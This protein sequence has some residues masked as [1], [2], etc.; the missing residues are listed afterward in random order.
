MEIQ[1]KINELM[2]DKDF[3]EAFQNVSAPEEVVELFGRNGV[4][5]PLAVAQE[6]FQ[7]VTVEGELTEN[8]LDDVA[9]GGFCGM[10][11]KAVFWGAGYLGARLANWDAAASRSY[12]NK[13][14]KIGGVLGSAMDWAI[15]AGL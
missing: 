14:S 5:V 15:G 2:Q 3:V 13:C 10:A 12:A 1:E 4:E 11:G 6:L 8:V 7:P 9:G